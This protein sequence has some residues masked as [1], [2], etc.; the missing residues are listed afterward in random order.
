MRYLASIRAL[1]I[2][3]AVLSVAVPAVAAQEP[4]PYFRRDEESPIEMSEEIAAAISDVAHVGVHLTADRSEANPGDDVRYWIKVVNLFN[5]DLPK[6]EIAFYF[7]AS[8]MQILESSGGRV[9]G[10]HVNF[11]VPAARSGEVSGFNLRVRLYNKLAPGEI[12]RTY[13]S[14]IW[15]G[16]ISPACSKHELRIIGRPPVTGAGDATGD[17]ENLR[18][19]LR[20]MNS[21]SAGSPMP[22]MIWAMVAVAGIAMGGRLGKK[23]AA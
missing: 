11:T 13:S 23:F 7:D 9:D 16:T 15:D 21:A 5:R 22:L 2:S 6:W 8:K 10:D 4:Y 3:I 19:F 18:A 14:M 12:I 20:P 17:V 1:L